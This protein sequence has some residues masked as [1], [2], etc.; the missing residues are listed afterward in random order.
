M[1]SVNIEDDHLEG[2]CLSDLILEVAI[3]P[4]RYQG[5]VVDKVYECRC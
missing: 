3:V 1:L 2:I 5:V 4:R